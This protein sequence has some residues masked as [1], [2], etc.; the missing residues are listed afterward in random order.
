[1]SVRKVPLPL[2]SAGQGGLGGPRKRRRRRGAPFLPRAIAVGLIPPWDSLRSIACRGATPAPCPAGP[3]LGGASGAGPQAGGV[4]PPPPTNPG[5]AEEPG[6]AAAAAAAPGAPGAP[7]APRLAGGGGGGGAHL[8]GRGASGRIPIAEVRGLPGRRGSA[9]A[10]LAAAHLRVQR[11]DAASESRG[12]FSAAQMAAHAASSQ[13]VSAVLDEPGAAAPPRASAVPPRP[14][15]LLLPLHSAFP[16]RGSAPAARSPFSAAAAAALLP[17]RGFAP[18]H[19]PRPA[20]PVDL[21]PCA[22]PGEVEGSGAVAGTERDL[23]RT[24]RSICVPPARAKELRH[25][26]EEGARPGAL[27]LRLYTF[28]LDGTLPIADA[29]GALSSRLRRSLQRIA[30]APAPQRR[31]EAVGRRRAS[32]PLKVAGLETLYLSSKALS[33]PPAGASASDALSAMRVI[34]VRR[35]SLMAMELRR[36]A[37]PLWARSGALLAAAEAREEPEALRE[38][39]S[40]PPE[41]AASLRALLAAPPEPPPLPETASAAGRRASRR[42][43]PLGTI[44]P[45]GRRP[46][47]AGRTAPRQCRAS[48]VDAYVSLRDRF[49]PRSQRIRAPPSTPTPPQQRPQSPAAE[50]RAD[51]RTTRYAEM[52]LA[53]RGSQKPRGALVVSEALLERDPQIVLL[54]CGIGLSVADTKLPPGVDFEVSPSVAGRVLDARRGASADGLRDTVV[55]LIAASQRYATFWVLLSLG[56]DARGADAAPLLKLQAACL[57]L[58]GARAFRLCQSREDAC[59]FIREARDAAAAVELVDLADPEDRADAAQRCLDEEEALLLGF[60]CMSASSVRHLL[61]SQTLAQLFAG[62][63]RPRAG[64]GEHERFERWTERVRGRGVLLAA[65][66]DH[67]LRQLWR[68]AG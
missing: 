29:L 19:Q 31:P 30:I 50:G 3:L 10:V 24:L 35:V 34:R 40:A 54:L 11:L 45:G 59:V 8:A 33:E 65:V 23:A 7:G 17:W 22:A 2:T 44:G 12:V 55:Q 21:L 49:F 60:P 67:C 38:A 16:E 63:A 4:W 27:P 39:R 1:M 58:P 18:L 32:R 41:A 43:Q 15:L 13:R 61:S 48:V 64:A 47:R 51:T 5:E 36:R 9:P 62:I 20:A 6:A 66:S 37:P 68:M 42:P 14:P 25:P 46:I 28:D 57:A 26:V 56:D 52:V 53:F